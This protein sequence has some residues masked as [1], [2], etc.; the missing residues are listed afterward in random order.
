MNVNNPQQHDLQAQASVIAKLSKLISLVDSAEMK[1]SESGK[2]SIELGNRHFGKLIDL[3][4][5]S[6]NSRNIVARSVVPTPGIANA[7]NTGRTDS[8]LNSL[9]VKLSIKTTTSNYTSE[10]EVYTH[11]NSLGADVMPANRWETIETRHG[12]GVWVP[13][14]NAMPAIS[15]VGVLSKHQSTLSEYLLAPIYYDTPT[16]G[17]PPIT[18][19]RFKHVFTRGIAVKCMYL[20]RRLHGYDVAH[21]D[22]HLDNIVIDIHPT[23]HHRVVSDDIT[24]LPQD[25][26]SLR[27]IDFDKS[28]IMK[29]A[30]IS[31]RDVRKC[32][33][34]SNKIIEVLGVR[35]RGAD[36]PAYRGLLVLVDYYTVFKGGY[37]ANLDSH[38]STGA[39][40]CLE[41]MQKIKALARSKP[42]GMTPQ[43]ATDMVFKSIVL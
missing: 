20:L 12:E 39:K 13:L 2:V 16:H 8:H 36:I 27:F 32:S 10:I 40:W 6:R 26:Y 22:A 33:V 15:A 42:G 43:N 23:E 11:L 1:D 3:E 14:G 25:A 41:T 37:R 21:L 35:V 7:F 38:Y 17:A 34:L 31:S 9:V 30:A 18:P 24:M 19:S 29:P 28:T 5:I 4:N